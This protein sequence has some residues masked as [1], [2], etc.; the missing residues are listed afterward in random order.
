MGQWIPIWRQALSPNGLTFF[1]YSNKTIFFK[2]TSPIAGTKIR[3]RLANYYGL[4][5]YRMPSAAVA[6]NGRVIRLTSAGE[7]CIF[8]NK[9][10]TVTTDA[11]GCTVSPGDPI[12]I[13][14]YSKTRRMNE[15]AIEPT[16][17][18]SKRGDWSQEKEV[19]CSVFRKK[20]YEVGKRPLP[21]LESIEVY[22]KDDPGVIVAFG[23]SI[24]QQGTWVN[25]LKQRLFDLYRSDVV[26]LN[27]GIGGNRLLHAGWEGQSAIYGEAAEK[28][29]DRDVLLIPGI[30][31]VIIA[32]GTNDIGLTRKGKT[33]YVT[34]EQILDSYV[35][36]I[37]RAKKFGLRVIGTTLLPRKGSPDYKE[38]YKEQMRQEINCWIREKSPYDYVID[39]D[40]AI[41]DKKDPLRIREGCC[42]K[43][44]L[45]PNKRGGK[46]LADAVEIGEL[47]R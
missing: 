12:E 33:D 14:L 40:K 39:F 46:I 47:L 3:L 13:R 20:V 23:D 30:K 18:W 21:A 26:L 22:T 36:L 6:V 45:H 28:R 27:S 4:E 16:V 34:T 11:A 5:K 8:I 35:R 43:D 41:Q 24:T 29:F 38:P 44:K 31:S 17:F 25:P 37:G 2:V 10:E 32:L 19:P 7:S 9:K 1:K 15:N 42:L